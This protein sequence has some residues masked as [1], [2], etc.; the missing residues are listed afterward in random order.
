MSTHTSPAE[1]PLPLPSTT[2]PAHALQ[3]LSTKSPK[4]ISLFASPP[5]PLR[6]YGTAIDALYIHIPFCSTKCHYCDFYSLAGHLDRVDD[7]L[8]AFATEVDLQTDFFGRI[9]PK[10]IFIGGGTPTLLTPVQI[11]TYLEKIHAKVDFSRLTEFT[12]EAN[13]NTFDAEKA[14]LLA[15][16]GV[17]R[18]SFGAQSFVPT[19]LTTL[20]RDHDPESVPL[21]FA[22]ARKAGIHNL[23]LD[24]IFGIPGQTLASW[25]YSLVRALEQ[26][27]SHIS[28]YSLT[29]EPT[30]AMTARLHRGEFTQLDEETE[31]AMFNH[32]YTRLRDTGFVRY[33][34][35][36]YARQSPTAP[37][38]SPLCQHNLAYWKGQNWLALGPS[39]G[40]HVALRQRTPAP[41]GDPI[42]WQW[43]NAGSLSHYLEALLPSNNKPPRLPF[44]Q[45]ESLN[46]T[47]WAAG[48]AVFWLRLAEGLNYE[49]FSART[50]INPEP[51]LRRVFARYVDL[52]I[53]ECTPSAARILE[54]GV[55]VSNRIL[56]DVLA[57]FEALPSLPLPNKGK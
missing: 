45:M 9:S 40:A 6:N 43:K 44:T 36:N 41:P 52:Q 57:A 50:G 8:Q 17:N 24:L 5:E 19:E 53:A 55:A 1:K 51:T 23:S 56:A 16:Y 3:M 30:T 28:C 34:T 48:V 18:I 21:A 11:A 38:P 54:K 26:N 33:E 13:P 10:T 12:I 25:E 35:S 49:E 4:A 15:Q 47:Q 46:R 27:P 14:A 20:Q 31:L 32:V 7:F 2:P 39:A 42:A 22:A 29:Y 37:P